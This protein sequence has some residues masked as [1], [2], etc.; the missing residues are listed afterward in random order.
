MILLN[1]YLNHIPLKLLIFDQT[2]SILQVNESMRD[3]FEGSGRC[4]TETLRLEDSRDARECRHG[5][6][7]REQL[8]QSVTN[9]ENSDGS[10]GISIDSEK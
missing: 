2:E 8:F 3:R 1:N 5:Q 9:R 10:M 6:I 4:L 7:D